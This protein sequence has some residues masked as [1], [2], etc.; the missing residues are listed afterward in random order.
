[1]KFRNCR[2]VSICL[3][4]VLIMLAGTV[5]TSE[6]DRQ[7]ATESPPVLVVFGASYAGD[8][9]TPPLSGF[10]VVNRGIGGNETQD[11]LD[12]VDGVLQ[13]DAPSV[14]VIWG[15]INDITRAGADQL[16]GKLQQTKA[17]LQEII[18]RVIASGARPVLATETTLS[19]YRSLDQRFVHY[20]YSMLGKE[21]YPVYVNKYVQ[22]VNEWV[23]DTAAGRDVPMLDIE[24]ILRG[25][26]GARRPE[27]S[28]EDGSH[29]SAEA[30]TRLTA[31]AERQLPLLLGNGHSLDYREP[32][33]DG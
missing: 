21:T 2:V 3:A 33:S 9:G 14:V 27:Y 5:M 15:F 25:E 12:R 32:D 31:F 22:S 24:L 16:P 6:A 8:W 10:R 28:N 20:A 30:Y 7:E 18:D 4:T 29:L 13:S 11:M 17:N 26:D 19:L 1:M 23:R